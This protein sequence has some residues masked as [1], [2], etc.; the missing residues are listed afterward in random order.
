MSVDES[1]DVELSG[2]WG[3]AAIALFVCGAAFLAARNIGPEAVQQLM[4]GSLILIFLTGGMLLGLLF[5]QACGAGMRWGMSDSS[6]TE[7]FATESKK[8]S[9]IPISEFASE[10]EQEVAAEETEE[11]VDPFYEILKQ[12]RSPRSAA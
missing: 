11:D 3:V 2:W 12:N 1:N 6:I 10:I 4:Q 8:Q 7:T 9:A 5:A